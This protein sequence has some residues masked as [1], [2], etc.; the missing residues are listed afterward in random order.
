[1]T[2]PKIFVSRRIPQAG[3]DMLEKVCEVEINPYNR[4]LNKDELKEGVKGKEGLLCL[5]TDTIDSEIMDAAE[6][7]KTIANYA[8]GYNNI[9]IN[10]ATKTPAVSNS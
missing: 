6:G 3:L 4:V 2:K 10:E 8:V 9:D 7:I 5:L 1:M